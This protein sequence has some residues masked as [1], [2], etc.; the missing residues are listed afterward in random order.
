MRILDPWTDIDQAELD[1]LKNVPVYI[2]NTGYRW[3]EEQ[4]KRTWSKRIRR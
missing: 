1:A 4:K 3:F 2:G